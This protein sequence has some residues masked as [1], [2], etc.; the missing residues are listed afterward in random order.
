MLETLF[1]IVY[2]AYVH[3][4]LATLYFCIAVQIRNDYTKQEVAVFRVIMHNL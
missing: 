3:L 1:C 2:E 4:V